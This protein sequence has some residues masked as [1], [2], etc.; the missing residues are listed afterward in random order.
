MIKKNNRVYNGLP[1]KLMNDIYD[2]LLARDK[3]HLLQQWW[4][5]FS[6]CLA[7]VCGVLDEKIIIK[8]LTLNNEIDKLKQ[9]IEFNKNSNEIKNIEIIRLKNKNNL[10]YI[11]DKLKQLEIDIG[12]CIIT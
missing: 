6:L 7:R 8:E 1:S 12:K 11:I 5:T 3:S 9:I 2:G 4:G 10:S